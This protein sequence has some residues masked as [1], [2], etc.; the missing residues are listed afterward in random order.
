MNINELITIVQN[1]LQKEI[2][3]QDLKIEDKSFLHKKHKQNLSNHC[4]LHGGIP[5]FFLY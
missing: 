4:A 3:I 2:I 1:K 5:L